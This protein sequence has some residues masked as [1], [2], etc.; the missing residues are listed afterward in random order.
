MYSQKFNV[1]K[2]QKFV[3]EYQANRE[4]EITCMGP[5]G[6]WILP[7]FRVSTPQLSDEG[8]V[9]IKEDGDISFEIKNLSKLMKMKLKFAT[10]IV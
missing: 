9:E 7:K 5:E 2:G 6:T 8:F 3:F 10:Q 1:K 4:F